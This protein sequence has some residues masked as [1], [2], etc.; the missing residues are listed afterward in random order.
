MGNN[1]KMIDPLFNDAFIR[2]FGRDESRGLTRSLVNSMLLAA[3]M[4]PIGAIESI[5]A[6]HTSLVGSVDCKT[7]RMDVRVISADRIVDLEAQNYPSDIANRSLFYGASLLAASTIRSTDYSDLPQVVVITLLNDRPMLSETDDFVHASRFEWSRPDGEAVAEASD[8]LRLVLVE[9]SK[10]RARY[11]SLEPGVL[12]NE[13]VAWSYL[14]TRGFADK[15]EVAAIMNQFPDMEEFARMYGYAVDDPEVVKA[16]ESA[17]SAEREYNSRQR[18][19]KQLEDEA[20]ARGL[21]EGRQEGI[22]QG[23]EKGIEQGI[24]QGRKQG[25]RQGETQGRAEERDRIAAR[26]REHGFS[27]H[28]IA[29]LIG[30]E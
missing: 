20:R 9:L 8:R 13:A 27:E 22:K 21:Q 28:D 6:E 16:Y 5:D 15:R 4:E 30:R 11:T 19:L 7:P 25:I 2:I 18:Y 17:L 29:A 1:A 23:I 14:L 10:I 26:M 24:E 3:G 12:E